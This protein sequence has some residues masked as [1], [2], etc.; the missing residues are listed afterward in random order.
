MDW[1]AIY[2]N[3]EILN[4]DEKEFED[5]D[6]DRLE[7]FILK[8]DKSTFTHFVNEGKCLVNKNE[9]LFSLNGRKLGFSN[10]VINFKEKISGWKGQEVIIGYYTGWKEKDENENLI[11]LLFW[12]DMMEQKIKL[13]LRFTPQKKNNIFSISINENVKNIKISTE[14]IGQKNTIAMNLQ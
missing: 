14:K 8:D 10:D 9:I 6:R 3:G 11:E 5:I 4:E 2:K 12:V 13:R 7:K 1:Q